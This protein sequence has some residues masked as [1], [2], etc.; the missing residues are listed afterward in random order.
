MRIYAQ[1]SVGELWARLTSGS[2]SDRDAAT[3]VAWGARSAEQAFAQIDEPGESRKRGR[4]ALALVRARDHKLTTDAQQLVLTELGQE[5]ARYGVAKMF[6]QAQQTGRQ[7]SAMLRWRKLSATMR[8]ALR[9]AGQGRIVRDAHDAAVL[10]VLRDTQLLTA[11]GA[12]T[13]LGRLVLDLGDLEALHDVVVVQHDLKKER[14]SREPTR[15]VRVATPAP[16]VASSEG[17]EA[18]REARCRKAFDELVRA[19]IDLAFSASSSIACRREVHRWTDAL[20]DCV[21]LGI[22]KS[23]QP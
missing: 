17:V 4:I 20:D 23:A 8:E 7:R 18:R 19:G 6:E 15:S 5:L 3:L 11:K 13:K 21:L 14:T 10:Q 2:L 22:V 12:T 9:Q 1:P 16:A